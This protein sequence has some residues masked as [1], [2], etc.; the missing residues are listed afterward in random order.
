MTTLQSII[1]GILQGLTEFLPV[2]SSGHLVLA[3]H[4][5]A[6]DMPAKDLAAFDV[7]LHAG[8][9]CALLLYFW[10]DWLN[11]LKDGIK[12]VKNRNFAD[13]LLVKIIMATIPAV[14]I[15]F[16]MK[17]YI[18]AYLRSPRSVAWA[19]FFVGTVLYLAELYPKKKQ[20][21]M[22]KFM[23]A[24]L[25]G[26]AQAIALIPGVS[27]S[28]STIAAAM[29]QGIDRHDAAKFSF[30]LGTPAIFGAF[31]LIVLKVFEGE[32]TLPAFSITA[33][34]FIASAISSFI[35]I[36][37]LLQFVK[38]HTLWIFSIYLWCVA[39]VVFIQYLL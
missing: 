18:E 20:S 21:K 2:S 12:V 29:F 37:F 36:H 33:L 10:K 23:Q 8:T 25:I 5:L 14:I 7:I 31:L 38:K 28:G 19:M 13:S 22:P 9:L 4:Y 39:G 24:F 3:Q 11:M 30:L 34:G 16:T 1:L 17:D 27:R 15:G 6:L 35:C 32:Y 26:C